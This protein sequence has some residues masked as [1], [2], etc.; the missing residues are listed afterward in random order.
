ME[1]VS[2]SQF[3][4]KCLALLEKVRRTG[5]PI[6]VTKRGEPVAQV[7]PPTLPRG[8]KPWLGSFSST[9][10]ITGDIVSPAAGPTEWDAL[11]S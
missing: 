1:T 5:Q 10:R 6:L 11:K 8:T 4:A 2:I 7:V 9:G 3:K